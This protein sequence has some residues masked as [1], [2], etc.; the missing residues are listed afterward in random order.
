MEHVP[1]IKREDL[2][3]KKECLVTEII[4]NKRFLLYRLP[5][6]AREFEEFCND[7]NQ[8]L[9]HVNNVNVTLSVM[10]SD[11]N[12]KSSQWWSLDKENA[13]G[14]EINC[15]TSACGYRQFVNKPTQVIKEPSTCINLI[16][17]QVQI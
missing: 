2:Y 1:I 11:F 9:S 15:L 17:Q 16:L 13:E 12:V 5:N 4:V 8:L 7:L 14:R 3:S 10:T 6:Q